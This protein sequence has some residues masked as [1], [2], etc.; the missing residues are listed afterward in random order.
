MLGVWFVSPIG[1]TALLFTFTLNFGGEGVVPDRRGLKI[2]SIYESIWQITAQKKH[3][4]KSKTQLC[5]AGLVYRVYMIIYI[6]MYILHFLHNIFQYRIKGMDNQP[7]GNIE[8][9]CDVNPYQV[10]NNL[11]TCFYI[12]YYQLSIHQKT[13]CCHRN[14]TAGPLCGLWPLKNHHLRGSSTK[15]VKAILLWNPNCLVCV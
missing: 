1:A 8:M 2:L 7:N 15:A 4:S 6:Y 10:H 5:L 12:I 14:H 3:A 11:S 9:W 13:C